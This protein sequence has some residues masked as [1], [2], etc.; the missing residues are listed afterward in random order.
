[1]YE[2][3]A[4]FKRN[5]DARRKYEKLLNDPDLEAKLEQ[6]LKNENSRK[7]KKLNEKFSGL[8]RIV[9]GH[10]PWS[11]SERRMTLGKVKA[12]CGFFWLT[13]YISHDC[14]MP[15]RLSNCDKPL[16]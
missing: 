6:A 4:N 15:S 14:S 5:T 11:T 8:L 10:T 12:L 13:F 2:T 7:A 3:C 1:M 9:G 16:Q